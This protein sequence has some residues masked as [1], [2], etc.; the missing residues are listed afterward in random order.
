MP[1]TDCKPSLIPLV[2]VIQHYLLRG[3]PYWLTKLERIGAPNLKILFG[4]NFSKLCVKNTHKKYGGYLERTHGA[5][6]P[7][8]VTKAQ[9]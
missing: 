3:K 7:P 5:P 4:G 2:T 9:R 1:L 6:I 8:R